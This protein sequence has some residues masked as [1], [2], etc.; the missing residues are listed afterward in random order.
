LAVSENFPSPPSQRKRYFRGRKKKTCLKKFQSRNIFMSYKRL[1]FL[2]S[3]TFYVFFN[4]K[5]K[6]KKAFTKK[7]KNSLLFIFFIKKVFKAILSFLESI[8]KF[9][10]V[11]KLIILFCLHG[12]AQV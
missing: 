9:L 8:L 5:I 1:T 7:K 6:H 11:W 12:Y 2:K 3:F 4:K 10:A